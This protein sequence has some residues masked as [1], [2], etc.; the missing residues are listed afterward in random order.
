MQ[1]A[2]NLDMLVVAKGI[3][4]SEQLVLMQSLDCNYGQG[5]LFSKPIDADEAGKLLD[6]DF[7]FT[8]AA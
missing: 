7:R 2:H 6:D 1:L 3:E 5:F 8:L 4:T